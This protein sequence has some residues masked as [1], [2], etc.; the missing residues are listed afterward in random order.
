MELF[1]KKYAE[2]ELSI[3]FQDLLALGRQD[4]NNSSE[5]LNMAYL[6]FRGS[7][8]VNGV[9]RLHG[10]VSRRIFQV[11]F[12]RWP[13]TE[14]PVTYVTNGVHM[15]TWDSAE[16]RSPLGVLAAGKTAGAETWRAS[17]SVFVA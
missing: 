2:E 11:L 10:Q 6:A 3:S 14:V 15:P 7:G 12:P 9:S 5:P 8:A 17:K 13:E 16:C 4:R 1:F